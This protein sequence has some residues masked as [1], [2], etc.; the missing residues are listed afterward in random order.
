MPL[1]VSSEMED[2]IAILSLE[3]TLTLGPQLQSVHEAV[4]RLLPAYQPR[5]LVIDASGLSAVDSAGLGEL[6]IVYSLTAKHKIPLFLS[7]ARPNLV[8]ALEMTHLDALLPL[9][10][11][12]QEARRL[13]SQRSAK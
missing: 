3:G 11:D 1:T 13:I 10:A 4:T 8:A 9:A 6:T 5:A 7:G 2:E 12:V